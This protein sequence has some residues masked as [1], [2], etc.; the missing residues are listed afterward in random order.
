MV[1]GRARY[2]FRRILSRYPRLFFP[3]AAGR[4][5]A[6][7][8]VAEDTELVIE[9]FSRSGNTWAV[10]AFELAQQRPV[11]LAHHLH[12][13]AQISRAVEL[14]IPVLLVVRQPVDAASSTVI[15]HPGVTLSQ[16][17]RAYTSFHRAVLPHLSRVVVAGFERI[18]TDFGSVTEEI[19]RRF[20]TSFQPFVNTPENVGCCFARIEEMDRE[21][22]TRRS[23]DPADTMARPVPAREAM[24]AELMTAMDDARLRRR[25]QR[26]E[27]M[28]EL[29]LAGVTLR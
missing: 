4:H 27:E 24:R 23:L 12:A 18:T 3:I 7:R 10:A 22:G 6:G 21:D 5:P 1:G 26:A 14:E 11:K 19:N 2:E 9:G 15:R 17:L 13:P 29:I 20:T 8:V 16:V 28:Y 25:R